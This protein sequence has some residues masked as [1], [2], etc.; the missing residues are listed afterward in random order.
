MTFAIILLTIIFTAAVAAVIGSISIV[1]RDGYRS[2]QAN[3]GY[4]GGVGSTR[5]TE[6]LDVIS[7]RS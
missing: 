4:L 6:P 7:A 5:A 1:A 3:A 2:I